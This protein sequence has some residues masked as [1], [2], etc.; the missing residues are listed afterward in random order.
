M[1]SYEGR[2]AVVT[3]ASSG[4]GRRIALELADRGAVVTGIAR[5]ESRLA[6]VGE[7]LQKVSPGS[8]T[9][10]CD[11]SDTDRYAALLAEIEADRG[12]VD[13]LVSSAGMERRVFAEDATLELYRETMDTNFFATVA[14]TL[15]VLPGML[16][17]GEGVILNVSSDHGRAPGPGTAAYCASK[18]AV[19]AFTESVSYEIEG[20]G[21]KLHVLYPGWVPTP[22]GQGAVDAGMPV[23]PKM[24][25]RTEEQVARLAVDRMGGPLLEINAARIATLA[26]MMRGLLPRLYRKGMLK[27]GA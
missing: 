4:L 2:I 19:S 6:G 16:A 26:P 17:R 1:R 23:P 5:S 3:G 21:V 20:R 18:A 24:V 10:P 14:G 8:G 27:A 22:L 15:A 9:R 7:Q 12:R 13:V 11:V 25:H